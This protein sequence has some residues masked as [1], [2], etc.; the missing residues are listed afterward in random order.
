MTHPID[1]T[2]EEM[3][4]MLWASLALR[5]DGEDAQAITLKFLTL[6]RQEGA[7]EQYARDV[8]VVGWWA[9]RAYSADDAISALEK[10]SPDALNH[11]EGK[12]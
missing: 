8:A 3:N 9:D 11:T 4:Q 2:V 7:R 10:V 6:A 5:K 12:G 1:K